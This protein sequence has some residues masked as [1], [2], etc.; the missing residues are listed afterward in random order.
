[1]PP[2]LSKFVEI[3]SALP[4]IGPRQAIRLAF[5]FVEQ[6]VA[7]ENEVAKTILA[8]KGIKTCRQCFY[9]HQNESGLCNICSDKNRNQN[10]IAIVEKETDLMS[11]ENIGQFSGRYLI[12]GDLKKT[13]VLET[14]QKLRLNSLKDWIRKEQDGKIEEII[15]ALNPSLQGELMTNLIAEEFKGLTGKISRLG[16]GI[17]SGGEIEFADEETLGSALKRRE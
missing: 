8:L 10:L 11:I 12:L 2:P 4:G 7:F 15:V 16:R 14:G 13:G 5:F 3:F 9:I 17:P 1:M 6:G